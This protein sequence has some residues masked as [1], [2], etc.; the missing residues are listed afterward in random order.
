MATR[1][2]NEMQRIMATRN[3]THHDNSYCEMRAEIMATRNAR[4]RD[5]G[6]GQFRL[7]PLRIC[8]VVWIYPVCY[9]VY[10]YFGALAAILC[11]FRYRVFPGI[12]FFRASRK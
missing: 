3:A 7:F 1:N 6:N 10:V 9:L 11:V 2:E 8:S 4:K 12:A 5:R